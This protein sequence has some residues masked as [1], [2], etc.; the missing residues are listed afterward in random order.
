MEQMLLI[1]IDEVFS[2]ERTKVLQMKRNAALAQ[3]FRAELRFDP[4]QIEPRARSMMLLKNIADQQLNLNKWIK[5][6]KEIVQSS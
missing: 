3:G 1:N 2:Y 6:Q 4:N 5:T